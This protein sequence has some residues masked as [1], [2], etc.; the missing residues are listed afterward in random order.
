MMHPCDECLENRWRYEFVDGWI[1]ATCQ[2]CANEV[3]FQKQRK[4]PTKPF[5]QPPMRYDKSMDLAEV[6]P[7]DVMPWE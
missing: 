1:T 5:D 2:G 3:M 6:R 7:D 4:G